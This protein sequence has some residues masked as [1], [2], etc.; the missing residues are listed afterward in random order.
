MSELNQGDG[1]HVPKNLY[2]A[3]NQVIVSR[4]EGDPV[5][6]DAEEFV[7]L[8]GGGGGGGGGVAG[9]GQIATVTFDE[10]YDAVADGNITVLGYTAGG[11]E[12]IRPVNGTTP[13][14]WITYDSD[15]EAV[16]LDLGTY[17]I[18]SKIVIASTTDP[19]TDAY[20]DG[21]RATLRPYRAGNITTRFFEYRMSTSATEDTNYLMA[22]AD[23]NGTSSSVVQTLVSFN[24]EALAKVKFR[25]EFT[26]TS[27]PGVSLG[28]SVQPY[29][30]ITRIG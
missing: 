17:L 28:L 10:S 25:L 15:A 30:T 16:Q 8:Y 12:G 1:T 29:V 22:S 11:D 9:A 6:M 4:S 14:E 7:T 13:P 23:G 5:A 24:N 20:P 18:T 27:L 2:T 21:V 19:V 26:G 3:E